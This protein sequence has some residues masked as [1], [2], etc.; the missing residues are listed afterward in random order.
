MNRLRVLTLNIWN[1]Q[2]PWEQRLPLLRK[3]IEELEPDIVGL[4]EVISNA[5]QTQADLIAEGLGLHA[6]FGAAHDLG[7]NVL[8]GNAILARWPISKV[9]VF[10][11]PT[12]GT[13][14][15]R[16]LTYGEV[17]SPHGP[18]P[19]F[20]T[21]LN[22]KFHHGFVREHQVM[23]I[24]E[25]IRRE[26]PIEGLPPV[27]VGD[28]NAQPESSEIRFLKGLHSLSG[29][30]FFMADCYEQTGE[31]AGYTFDANKNPYAAVTHEYPRRIDYVF[32]RGPDRQ[33]RGKPL[34]S[35]VVMTDVV[36]GVAPTD[37]FGVLAEIS[38]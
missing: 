35:R 19:F 25:H 11:L 28:M 6:A 12:D 20:V 5:G 17:A 4:Q 32:V 23:T 8:F 31:G 36:D 1:R 24:A 15:N 21:H 18:V 3:G 13:D 14:E 29:K 22:W 26:A 27:L 9:K 37:H 7:E 30:S 10:Q 2:G 16:A 34:S 33:A 38:I